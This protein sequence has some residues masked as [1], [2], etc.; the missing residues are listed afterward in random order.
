MIKLTEQE[1]ESHTNAKDLYSFRFKPRSIDTLSNYI[2]KED[3]C[4][5]IFPIG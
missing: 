5:Y 2:R 3:L 4:I 1:Q